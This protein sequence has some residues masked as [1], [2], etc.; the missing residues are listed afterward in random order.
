MQSKQK[1]TEKKNENEMVMSEFNLLEE[2][3]NVFKLVGPVMAKQSLF[4]CKDMVQQ[5]INFC[6]K[7]IQRLDF[8]EAE[9]QKKIAEKTTKVKTLQ[10][11]LQKFVMQ[12]QQAQAQATAK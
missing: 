2:D 5:R 12:L 7:E 4:D 9:F 8:M 10:S 11:D 6:D 1:M 3:A